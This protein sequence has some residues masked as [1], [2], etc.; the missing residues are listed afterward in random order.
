[1]QYQIVYGDAC[2][3]CNRPMVPA[4][5]EIEPGYVEHNNEGFCKTCEAR[6]RRRK[7]PGR[8]ILTTDDGIV[9]E[10]AVERAAKGDL[11]VRATLVELRAAAVHLRK[12]AHSEY[13]IAFVLGMPLAF[14]REAAQT[15]SAA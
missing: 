4:H 8:P 2:K 13:D 10:I 12:M 1:M 6:I 14:V 5:D 11:D 15:E 9:D 3:R 7:T